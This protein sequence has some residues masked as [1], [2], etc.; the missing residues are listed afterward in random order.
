MN[1]SLFSKL[2]LSYIL[3]ILV[4]LFAVG[5]TLSHLFSAYYYS[6]KEAELVRKGKE[7]AQMVVQYHDSGGVLPG[8]VEQWLE[9][10]DR[11]LDARLLVINKEGFIIGTT[12]RSRFPHGMRLD[13]SEIGMVLNGDVVSKQGFHHRFGQAMISVGIPIIVDNQVIG[14]LLLNA[15]VSGLSSTVTSVRQLIIYA[16]LAAVAFASIVGYG[17]SKSI[18][19]PLREM[20][21]VTLEMAK[22]NFKQKVTVNSQDEVGQLARNFNDLTVTLDKTINALAKEKGKMENILDNMAE[23]VVAVDQQNNLILL[24]PRAEETFGVN[25]SRVLGK[26]IHTLGDGQELSNLLD[27]VLKSGS[28]G[29]EVMEFALEHG[30]KY[31]LAHASSLKSEKETPFGAVAVLQDITEIRQLDQ[32][33]RDF[34][35]NVSH[36]LRTPLTSIRAFVEALLDSMIDDTATQQRY[37]NVIHDETL[38]LDRLIHDLLDLALI[39]SGKANWDLEMVD[40]REVVQQVVVKLKHLMDQKN[41]TLNIDLAGEELQ[42]LANVDRMQQVLI[43]LIS[44]SIQFTSNNG[45]ISI[46]VQKRDNQVWVEVNDNG[47]G[48]PEEDLP[49]IWERFHRVDKSRARHKGGTGLGLSIVKLI[50]EAHGGKVGADSKL[51]Q[52]STFYFTLPVPE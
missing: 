3:I 6:S 48:I 50:V 42:V 22:G 37:L 41:L 46:K 14:G 9:S 5:I 35:A 52:G 7:I 43:N 36:E 47:S 24:N 18:S 10:L 34:V 12:V 26:P 20:S 19:R 32:L 39:E 17:L 2:L 38:R 49:Y 45:E 44:N 27:R 16:A 21:R 51:G 40:L 11:F 33:R 25:V 30:K 31:I 8:P 23:G 13:P 15:P 1:K 4:A 28:K 29:S